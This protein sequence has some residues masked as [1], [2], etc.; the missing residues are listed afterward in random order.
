MTEFDLVVRAGTVVDGSGGPAQ[1]ADVGV[2]DGIVVEV[3]AGLGRGAQEIDADG[4]VVAPGFVDIHTHYDGQVTWD[5]RLQPSSWHGVTTA[6]MGNCGVGFAPARPAERDRL[7]ELMEGVEDIPGV[8]LTEGL[9]WTWETFGEY[10][11]YLETKRTDMDFAAQVPHAALRIWAM[12]KRA[13]ALEQATPAEAE[14]MARLA[15]QAIRDGAIGFSTARTLLHR[16]KAGEVDPNYGADRD[17]LV[18][19][20]RAVGETGAGVLQLVTDWDDVDIDLDICAGMLAASGRPLSVVVLHEQSDPARTPRVLAGLQ[21]LAD[22]GHTVHAQMSTRPIGIIL[23]LECTLNPFRNTPAYQRIADLP[24]AERV[25]AM[26]TA[27]VRAQ[28]LAEGIITEAPTT[29]SRF[30]N[31][32]HRMFELTDPPN[33]EP[34]PT[35]TIEVRA[36]RSGMSPT[37]LIYDIVL[38]DEGRGQ[39]YLPFANYVDG[40]LDGLGESLRHPRVLPGLS[41]GGAHVGTTSDGSLPTT[42]LQYWVRDRARGRLDLAEVIHRQARRTALAVGLADRGLLQPGYRADLNVIDLDRLR[43]HRPEMHYDLPAGG[44]RLLQRADGY[45][46]TFVAG[47]ET[48]R[49][50]QPTD[51]LPGRLVRGA[52]QG[53]LAAV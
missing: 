33:Y 5:E 41:D 53:M 34:D 26:Q 16:T 29:G 44:R 27:E 11:D 1:T 24:L 4:A 39:I 20:A 45:R 52:R 51:A 23:G 9:P 15:A 6:V 35:E 50:G 2:R 36:G 37:E 38:A 46:H 31:L 43:L 28:I 32:Y 10:L 25:V 48:Y 17:E 47:Q 14:E 42:L 40:S 8:T 22:E 21:Q 18:T 13:S 30:L 12:G 49:D 19:I 7:I 3:G